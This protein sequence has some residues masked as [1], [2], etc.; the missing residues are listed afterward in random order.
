MLKG[1]ISERGHKIGDVYTKF[2]TD[3]EA[4]KSGA[5]Y[6]ENT[7]GQMQY[8][9]WTNGDAPVVRIGVAASDGTIVSFAPADEVAFSKEEIAY[10]TALMQTVLREQGI[11]MEED[12]PSL[13]KK[14]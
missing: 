1:E 13:S 7:K 12:A 11:L 6:D 9:S 14:L 10:A 8:I 5:Y 4:E 3:E 2:L